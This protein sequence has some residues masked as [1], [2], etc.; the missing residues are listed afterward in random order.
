MCGIQAEVPDGD[1]RVD[2]LKFAQADDGADAV[3]PSCIKE[4]DMEGQVNANVCIM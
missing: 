4:A 2:G 3:M 1:V